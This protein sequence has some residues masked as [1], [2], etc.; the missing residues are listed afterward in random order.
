M[1]VIVIVYINTYSCHTLLMNASKI[2]AE[3]VVWDHI[4][5]AHLYQ[6]HLI[7]TNSTNAFKVLKRGDLE[8]DC[9]SYC[10]SMPVHVCVLMVCCKSI[11][12]A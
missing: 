7:A 6:W 2:S 5:L 8:Y 11:M 9:I 1:I 4:R 12:L 3:V 10:V